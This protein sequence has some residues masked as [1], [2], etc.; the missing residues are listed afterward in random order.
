[1][2]EGKLIKLRALEEDDLP[3]LR[4]W[5]N[6]KDIRIMTREYR[7]LNMINQKKWFETTHKEN[8]PSAIM[9]G[10]LN[11]KS[12]LI[13]VCGLTYIDW[14]NKHAE[15]SCYIAQNNW[16]KSNEVV[17]TLNVLMKYGFEEL[18]LHRLW[19]E[20]FSIAEKNIEL[21]VKMKFVNEGRLRQKLWRN[22]KWWDSFIF[23]KLST[24]Y[25]RS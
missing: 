4:D 13:G 25:Q 5:R 14:K 6:N 21:F 17:D 22:G 8:P 11:K 23:S 1:M 24:E 12:K 16:Q 7:L 9:F 2:L 20:I 19:A 10:I 18:N 3:R 15:I